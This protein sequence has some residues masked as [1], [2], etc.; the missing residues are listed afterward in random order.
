M[1]YEAC[2][3]LEAIYDDLLAAGQLEAARAIR[4]EAFDR[5]SVLFD[6]PAHTLKR[7]EDG[8]L[9]MAA[10]VLRAALDQEAAGIAAERSARLRA[11]QH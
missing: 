7:Y 3:I 5:Y 8:G 4:R 11:H 6:T 1:T 10:S 9:A 2:E